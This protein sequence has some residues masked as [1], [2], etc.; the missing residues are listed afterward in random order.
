[1]E[2][3]IERYLKRRVETTG[4]RCL[5]YSN[6]HEA[7]FPDRL[8]LLPFGEVVWVELKTTK[9]RVS[10]IQQRRHAQLRDMGHEVHIIRTKEEVDNFVSRLRDEI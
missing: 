1:M 5:K 9:G 2:R 7:G 4:C 10:P 6:P 8:I 3:E